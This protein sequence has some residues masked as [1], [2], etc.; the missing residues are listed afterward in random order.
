MLPAGMLHCSCP[1]HL[2]PLATLATADSHTA[3]SARTLAPP[4]A[5]RAQAT[6]DRLAEEL[7]AAAQLSD[8]AQEVLGQLEALRAEYR[9]LQGRYSAAVELVGERDEQ[10]EELRADLADVKHLYRDQI[11]FMCEQLV[12]ATTPRG[13]AVQLQ[14]QLPGRPASAAAGQGGGEAAGQAQGVEQ[15]QGQPQGQQQQQQQA[16]VS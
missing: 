13:S 10:V 16:G 8:R 15:G 12:A 5:P 14:L 2:S 1:G 4:T 9:E 6:R 7:V 3:N 11:E